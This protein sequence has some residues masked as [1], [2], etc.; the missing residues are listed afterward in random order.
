MKGAR[1]SKRPVPNTPARRSRALPWIGAGVIVA[2]ALVVAF[3][4]F[5]HPAGPSSSSGA[6][7]GAA[8]TSIGQPA[9]N[10]QTVSLTQLRGSK[11]VVYFYEES[12]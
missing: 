8:A 11:V 9:T 5:N 7:L 2:A 12:G 4:A 6:P 3:V 10:G 1:R